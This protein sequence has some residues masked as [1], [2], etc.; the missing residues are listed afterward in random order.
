MTADGDQ[1]DAA[2]AALAGAVQGR[3]RRASA[4]GRRPRRGRRARP[5]RRAAARARLA[6]RGDPRR[7]CRPHGS[8]PRRL[9][10][11]PLPR[12]CDRRRSPCGCDRARV[13][14]RGRPEHGALGPL[15]PAATELEQV[16]L[17][18]LADLLELP[19]GGAVFTSGAAGANLVSLAVARHDVGRRHGVD[20][21]RDGVRDIPALAVYGS[22]ELHFTNVKAL[23]TLGLGA[24]CVRSVEVDADDRLDPG[25]L[26]TA[27]ARD[28]SDRRPP[29]DRDRPRRLAEHRRCRP[30]ARDR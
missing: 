25:A 23:R 27:I 29:R 3:A 14:R 7:A 4:R 30:V 9:H 6:G 17:G 21:N 10:G 8:G 28:R 26:E 12:L 16:V 15:G 22:T 19:R 24:D 20:V 18:W 1:L 2:V 5:R 11:G 13:G